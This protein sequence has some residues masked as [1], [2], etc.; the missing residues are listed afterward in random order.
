MKLIGKPQEEEPY[1]LG[2]ANPDLWARTPDQLAD[3]IHREQELGEF[4][5]A[6]AQAG[7][8]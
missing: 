4:A 3:A 7:N 1:N 6:L 5:L 8:H 2:S